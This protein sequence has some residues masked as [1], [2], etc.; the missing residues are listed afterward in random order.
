VILRY[1]RVGIEIPDHEP[2][3]I[4]ESAQKLRAKAGL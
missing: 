2:D 3:E 4:A 1:D